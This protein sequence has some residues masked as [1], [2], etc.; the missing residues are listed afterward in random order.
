MLPLFLD[1]MAA[2]AGATTSASDVSKS[3]I[4]QNYSN[5]VRPYPK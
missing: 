1:V 4:N 3:H 5:V 2:P